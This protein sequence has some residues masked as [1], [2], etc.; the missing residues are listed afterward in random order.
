[1]LPDWMRGINR[2]VR[3]GSRV[4]DEIGYLSDDGVERFTTITDEKL[5]R[6]WEEEAKEIGRDIARE[7]PYYEGEVDERVAEEADNHVPYGHFER[8]NLFT[9][10]T[11]WTHEM[12]DEAVDAQ[13]QDK[14]D[15]SRL[16]AYLLYFQAERL[17]YEGMNEWI[18]S[19]ED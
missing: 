16:P 9:Q 6:I 5:Y 17:I 4:G 12:W 18:N 15:S 2:R 3:T 11:L 7:F 8:W 19:N 10:G 13:A 1:M 14:G